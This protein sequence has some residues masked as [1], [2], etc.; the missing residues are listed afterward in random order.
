MIPRIYV[1]P[2]VIYIRWMKW[3]WIIPRLFPKDGI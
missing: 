2:K 1:C 3:E